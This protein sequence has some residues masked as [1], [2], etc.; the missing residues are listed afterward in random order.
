MPVLPSCADS[1]RRRPSIV[2][3]CAWDHTAWYAG[4][5]L[6]ACHLAMCAGH[7]LCPSPRGSVG[8]AGPVEW[9]ER[10]F[11]AILH[12]V[13]V[14]TLLADAI[15]D[16]DCHECPYTG[17]ANEDTA[18]HP[19]LERRLRWRHG[20][21]E[22]PPWRRQAARSLQVTLAAARFRHGRR[23]VRVEARESSRS[24]ANTEARGPDKLR[25]SLPRS[26]ET[27]EELIERS[28]RQQTST[29]TLRPVSDNGPTTRTMGGYHRERRRGRRPPTQHRVVQ[30]LRF[31]YSDSAGIHCP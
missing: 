29:F 31:E 3:A 11:F 21:G 4:T 25:I 13:H 14:C 12:R 1:M 26:A 9:T 19:S 6:P 17:S 28:A 24:S 15:I 8:V 22:A 10:V 7:D 23:D 20:R 2:T 5:D 30:C 18:G 27:T 16:E